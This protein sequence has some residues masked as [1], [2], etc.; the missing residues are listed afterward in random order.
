MKSNAWQI[1]EA[2]TGAIL[3]QQMGGANTWSGRAD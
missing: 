3:G 1:V 2:W